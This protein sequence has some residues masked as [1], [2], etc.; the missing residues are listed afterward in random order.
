MTVGLPREQ[1]GLTFVIALLVKRLTNSGVL[2][3]IRD[4]HFC[5]VKLRVGQ[6]LLVTDLLVA[7]GVPHAEALFRRH[8]VHPSSLSCIGRRASSLHNSRYQGLC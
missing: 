4:M 1:T 5:S 7:C 2:A 8:M 3:A 6:V